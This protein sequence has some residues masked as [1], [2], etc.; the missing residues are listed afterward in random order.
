MIHN[1]VTLLKGLYIN[2]FS[3]A[4]KRKKYG[5][6]VNAQNICVLYMQMI[7]FY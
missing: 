2:D 7:L 6:K 5:I 1:N 3:E 4:I